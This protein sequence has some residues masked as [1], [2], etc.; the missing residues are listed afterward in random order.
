MPIRR[1][2][3]DAAAALDAARAL[4]QS[5]HERIASLTRAFV[6]VETSRRAAAEA[7]ATA[8]VRVTDDSALRA[9]KRQLRALERENAALMTQVQVL[10]H[11]VAHQQLQHQTHLLTKYAR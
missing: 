2:Y 4:A 11:D 6:A 8:S 1:R 7:L 5:R 10:R 3:R 9:L